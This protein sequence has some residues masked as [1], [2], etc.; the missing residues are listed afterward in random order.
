MKKQYAKPIKVSDIKT[1]CHP[2][3]EDCAGY[4]VQVIFNGCYN[5]PRPWYLDSENVHSYLN[6]NKTSSMVV[7]YSFPFIGYGII[8]KLA[9]KYWANKMRKQIDP[10]QN[11]EIEKLKVVDL[12]KLVGKPVRLNGYKIVVKKIAGKDK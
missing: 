2:G 6:P 12:S 11:P 9:T 7:V 3:K 4:K 1:Y 5:I 10:A 8:S